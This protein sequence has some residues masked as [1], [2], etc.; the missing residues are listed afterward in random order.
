MLL[1][2][3]VDIRRAEELAALGYDGIDVGLCRVIYNNDPYPHNPL[4]D[5]DDYERLLDE[6]IETCR[7]VGLKILTTHIPYRYAY[8]DPLSERY[9]YCFNMTARALKASEYLSAEWTVVHVKKPEETVDYVKRLIE[10]A[11]VTKIGIALENMMDYSIDELIAAHD[12]LAAE[13][14]RVGVCFDTGHAN[15]KKHFDIK[16]EDAIRALGSRIKML[17]VHDNMRNVDRHI[18][19]YFGCIRWKEVMTA[20][21][22]VGYEGALNM[23]L[24]P[25]K[26]PA[27][28]PRDA[29]EAY[30]VAIGKTLIS[31]F[32]EAR[33]ELGKA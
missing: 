2:A 20:L 7:R 3:N 9:D 18:A 8:N 22:E 28:A 31:M 6:H 33:R 17:H 4:L 10:A 23:E 32:E 11:G 1:S 26:I 29:Y 14:Y 15:V 27:G 5:G 19:P 12:M 16:V 13:G 25:E 24:Q 30:T 21:A